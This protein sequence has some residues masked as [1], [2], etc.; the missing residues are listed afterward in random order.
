MQQATQ[1][2]VISRTVALCHLS[3]GFFYYRY[4]FRLTL[5]SCSSNY[6]QLDKDKAISTYSLIQYL[7]YIQ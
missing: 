5:R 4:D 3:Q 1:I 6:L 2:F 7:N